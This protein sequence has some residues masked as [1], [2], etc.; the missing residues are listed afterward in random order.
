MFTNLLV[1]EP[2]QDEGCKEDRDCPSKEVCIVRNNRGDC[3]N[4]CATFTPCTTNAECKVYDTLPLRTMTCTCLPGFTGKGDQHCAPISKDFS[5]GLNSSNSKGREDW[6]IIVFHFPA[7]PVQAGCS[8][9][10]ECALS[11]A[12]RNRA[13][14]NPC[15]Q[16][17]PCSSSARCS[18]SNHKASCNC[19]PGTEGDPFTR[20]VPSKLH[21]VTCL[22]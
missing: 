21:S 10:D 2:V 7:A 6:L 17:N 1:P 5:I 20:C 12:C 3:K 8:S 4:P 9:D 13:C 19:P 15:V 11:Q 16:E 18:V 14:I 22:Y